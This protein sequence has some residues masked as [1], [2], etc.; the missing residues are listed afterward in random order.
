M[1]PG[2]RRGD[3]GG[4]RRPGVQRVGDPEADR[5]EE[6]LVRRQERRRLRRVRPGP[7]LRLVPRP[8]LDQP[9]RPEA[10]EMRLEDVV[11]GVIITGQNWRRKLQPYCLSK[12]KRVILSVA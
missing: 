8:G 4:R 3:G 5:P 7:G 9:R 6:Q 1:P 10:A 12:N 11:S 2:L